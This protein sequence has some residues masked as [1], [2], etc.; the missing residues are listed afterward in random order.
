MKESKDPS[1]RR[2]SAHRFCRPSSHSLPPGAA[3]TTPG[4]SATM[5]PPACCSP[6]PI[7]TCQTQPRPADVSLMFITCR[8]EPRLIVIQQDQMY[9]DM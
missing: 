2:R 6:G 4:R 7:R 9:N 1:T 3:R 8:R 5:L